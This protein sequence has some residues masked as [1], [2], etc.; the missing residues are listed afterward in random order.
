[1]SDIEEAKDK[2]MMGTE[3]RSMVMTED[4]KKLTAY[5]ESG[6]AIVALNE[7]AS[8]PIHKA[9]IIPRGRALGVV[10]TLPERDKYS[11]SR[12]YI[13]ANISKAMGGRI[14]EELIFGHEKVTSG[15]ASDIQMAT[16]LAKDMVTRF[17]MSTELGPQTFGE[18]EDEVFLG[19]SITR[20]QQM[21]EETA[22]KVDEEIKK[23]VDAGYK[24]AKKILTEKIDDMHKLAKALILYETLT[25]DEIMDLILK[26]KYPKRAED[27]KEDE[28]D[29]TSALGSLGLKP[30]P[31]H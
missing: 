13:E 31:A 26:N 8:D 30:K 21:S 10:W 6:H 24:R 23:I 12:E 25:G 27:L 15:A 9:T 2:V 4:D 11:H 19:R 1:M 16:K 14:A 7:K 28:K 20:H 22:K 5:H 17:G 3:R 29:K 18:N